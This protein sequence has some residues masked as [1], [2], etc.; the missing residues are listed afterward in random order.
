MDYINSSTWN[1]IW[2]S[3][4][5]FLAHC[6]IDDLNKIL[7]MCSFCFCLRAMFSTSFNIFPG[8][9]SAGPSP[10]PSTQCPPEVS[11][12]QGPS[13]FREERDPERCSGP[14]GL[15]PQHAS[16]D[17]SSWPLS[18]ADLHTDHHAGMRTGGARLSRSSWA[19]FDLQPQQSHLETLEAC[20]QDAREASLGTHISIHPGSWV[21][22]KA[23]W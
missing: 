22:G 19:P 21:V 11:A 1:A 20:C 14:P 4:T 7:G 16:H 2:T 5:N 8:Q 9:H 18:E 13:T 12:G 17:P 10:F 3:I 6:L 15:S 23:H